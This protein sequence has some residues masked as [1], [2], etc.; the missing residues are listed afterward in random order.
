MEQQ[1][2]PSPLLPPPPPPSP[3]PSPAVNCP[4]YCS[5]QCTPVCQ[6]RET[7]GMAQCQADFVRNGKGCYDSC[8]NSTCN[9]SPDKTACLNSGCSYDN[10]T[11]G[12]TYTSSCCS[13]CRQ[14]VGTTYSNCLNS[15]NKG[16]GYCMMDCIGNCQ[17]NCTIQG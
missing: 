3:A 5:T 12:N 14:A 17:K 6:A 11:C 2:G 8:S 4:L 13:W 16:F 1:L 9:Q 15:C 7:A 10:C